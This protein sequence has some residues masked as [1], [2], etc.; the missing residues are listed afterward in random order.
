MLQRAIERH[1]WRPEPIATFG[2]KDP[3]VASRNLFEALT[4][5]DLCHE[6][7][8]S[9]NRIESSTHRLH[10]FEKATEEFNTL[11][12]WARERLTTYGSSASI[13]V[14]I[15]GL[16]QSYPVVRRS[17]ESVFPEVEDI[18]RLV[19]IDS[20]QP[21]IQHRV[22]LDFINLLRWTC[23]S[24]DYDVLLQLAKSPYLPRLKLHRKPQK[25]FRERMTI[26]QYRS[27]LSRAERSVL[28]RAVQLAPS[29]PD[30]PIAFAD[31]TEAIL[32]LLR[33]C[34]YTTDSYD[35]LA[36]L[37]GNAIKVLN[38]LVM[39]LAQVAAIRPRISWRRFI[40]LVDILA[41]DQ[42]I[43]VARS[44]APIQVMGRDASSYLRFDALWVTGV[45]DVDWP[46]VPRPN[47]FLPRIMQK[48]ANLPGISH[49][50]M[51]EDARVLTNHWRSASSEVVFS[52]VSQIDKVA[53]QPSNLFAD[54]SSEN[55]AEDESSI[56]SL[57][58]GFELIEYGHPWSTFSVSGVIHEYQQ[59]YGSRLRQKMSKPRRSC[60]AIKHIARS[61]V[62]LS[63]VLD[64]VKRK[65]L[66]HV[67]LRQH[68]AA[69]FSTMS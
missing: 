16:S 35:E 13:G 17:F 30:Q 24:L 55:D 52:Y 21:L 40:D 5:R 45:S 20:G 57:V 42:T 19:S 47:P 56:R 14:V 27:R 9:P 33:L 46:A 3:S 2:F 23:G 59:A 65:H 69:R 43:S 44:E 29:R 8:E 12:L 22:Y 1:D 63:I 28:D 18:T 60:S 41:A 58:D 54:L 48:R 6:A 25:W 53:A 7:A 10:G 4:R 39:R 64:S 26:R 32:A 66:C 67:S 15:N 31:A 11:A 37:D 49:E 68:N 50:Q 61:K 38:D 36:Y 34:G 51:L 62:G